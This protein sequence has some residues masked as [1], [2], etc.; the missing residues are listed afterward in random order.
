LKLLRRN[1]QL[2]R[3]ILIAGHRN[4]HHLTRRP[5]PLPPERRRAERAV[6]LAPCDEADHGRRQ[7][8]LGAQ[9]P[10]EKELAR[11]EMAQELAGARPANLERLAETF[12][13]IS[14]KRRGDRRMNVRAPALLRTGRPEKRALANRGSS[15]L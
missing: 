2:H 13:R 12:H 10:L 11:W 9:M 8:A 5:P 1:P 3:A 14:S 15:E 7:R 4:G 6:S